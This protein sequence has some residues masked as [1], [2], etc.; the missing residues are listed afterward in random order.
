MVRAVLLASVA[1]LASSSKCGTWCED[2]G[3]AKDICDCGVCGSFGACS[4]SCTEGGGR[5]ACPDTPVPTPV[6]APSPVPVPVPTPVPSPPVPVPTP[7]TG[8]T[9][10]AVTIGGLVCDGIQDG[11]VFYPSD[12]SKKYPLLA[13]AHGWTEGGQFTDVNY[14]DVIES[15]AAAGYV[16]IAHH[17]GL[18]TEC[19]PIYPRDQQ[20]ALA[21]VK[22]TPKYANM[23]DWDSKHGIYGHSMG[24][25]ATGDNAGN[26]SA[27]D[28]HN[29][30]AAVLLHPVAT[31]TKTLIPSLYTTGS[32][33]TICAP[34]G[35]ESWSKTATKPFIFAEM[36]GATHFE[37]Q[38]SENG[39][40]CPA[41]W[42]NYVVNWF[43]CHLKGMQDECNAAYSVCTHP[44]KPMTKTRCE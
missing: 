23:V 32:A 3:H 34:G 35:C 6:P 28:V 1:V 17:S 8:I 42:T 13:F 39:L 15:V 7:V 29:L 10:D 4:F 27:I 9:K 2:N 36:A 44:T 33:D 25:G 30:G 12:T 43:N 16:V 37:C 18:V 22:E 14:K 21:F 41:G 26:R 19:Q 5:V 24:G 11:S 31:R 40:P 20:R 38:T